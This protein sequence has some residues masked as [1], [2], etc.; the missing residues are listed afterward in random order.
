MRSAAAILRFP[1]LLDE[2]GHWAFLTDF[3]ARGIDRIGNNC[4]IGQ[5]VYIDSEVIIGNG[6]KLQNNVSVYQHVTLEDDVFCGPSMVFTNVYN[7]RAHLKKMSEAKKTLVKKGCTIG[8]NATVVCGVTLGEFS[9]VGA[10]SVVT[11]NVPAY[12]LV[13][14]NPAR[15]HGWICAC[16]EKLLAAAGNVFHCSGCQSEYRLREPGLEPL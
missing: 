13:Y 16:G 8:A 6:C 10:G 11:R 5:N 12:A 2:A 3:L 9:F 4:T 15:R 1:P 7:P 14:G